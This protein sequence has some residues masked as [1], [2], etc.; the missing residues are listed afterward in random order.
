[1]RSSI[2]RIARVLSY[3]GAGNGGVFRRM[4]MLSEA[5]TER[6]AGTAVKKTNEVLLMRW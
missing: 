2:A 1:M 5:E 4:L 3:S 6:S